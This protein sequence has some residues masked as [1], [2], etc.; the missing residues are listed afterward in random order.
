MK[1]QRPGLIAG[2]VVGVLALSACGSDNTDDTASGGD[3]STGA[4]ADCADGTLSWDG[5]SAQKTAVTEWIQK[6]QDK[7]QQA[8]INYQGQGS[9]SGRTAFY[10]GQIPVAGSDASIKDEDQ[11]KA[12]TRCTGGKAVNLPMVLTPV[13]F[14]YN[15]SG[16]TDLTLTPEILAK[17][18][19][20]K[21]I[22]WNDPEIAKANAGAS[23][24]DK[25]VTAVHRSKDSGTTENFTKFLDAQA[26]D[27]WTFGT[28]Q[29][30]TAPGG[31]GA[32]DSSGLVQS[33][34]STDGG[35]GYVDGPDA[36][37]N[38]LTPGQARRGRGRRRAERGLGR[39]G[40][41]R[42][43]GQG[44]RAGH[45]TLDQLRLEGRRHIPG[46][47]GHLRDHLHQGTAGRPDQVRQVVPHLHRQR[48][49]SGRARRPGLLPAAGR[50]GHQGPLGGRL[51]ERRADPSP[52]SRRRC[53]PPLPSD[54]AH[55]HERRRTR[56]GT[57]APEGAVPVTEQPTLGGS[58]GPSVDEPVTGEVGGSAVRRGDQVFRGLSVSAG[59][60]VLLIMAAITVFLIY[61]SIPALR[62]NTVNFLTFT[63]W[64]PDQSSAQFGIAALL[65]HTLV[66]GILAMIIAVPVA[67]GIALFITYY[68]PRRA[69]QPLGYFVDLLAAV[70]SIVYGLWGFAFLAPRLGGLTLWLDK[71]LGWIPIF[72]YQAQNR[73]NN[74]T[75]FTAG[76]V[77]AIMILPIISSI[78][79]EVFRQVPREQ[80]EAA[81][82]LGATRW[83]M[84]RTAVLPFG[85]AGVV[86]AAILGLGRALGET[87]AVTIV[88]SNVYAI[89]WHLTETGGVTFASNI[90]LK[91]GEA[92]EIGTGALIFS[93]LCLFVITLVVNFSAQLVLTRQQR[94]ANR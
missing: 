81:L 16:V 51:A 42:S 79:R 30:W 62:A 38:S 73:P 31:Q 21:I 53:A 27:V 64:L 85:R 54:G 74:L 89:S 60:T 34:K 29:A 67:I 25:T 23:L 17:I 10:G 59:A 61:R 82:A 80:V 37:K 50:A 4:S 2:L 56:E 65:F 39:Q 43:R 20:G 66:T 19:S 57:R 1:L 35:I 28:G 68:T 41:L 24:P 11:S 69:A 76:I 87:L 63:Q 32:P 86:S 18:F 45:Q 83:E 7:C 15:L 8:S 94:R 26:K 78:S 36:K 5:S 72:D 71:W 52:V 90:A 13:E 92:S 70:P 55:R 3:S 40:D 91:Y 6:Y 93:G 22:N 44:G 77:L 49:R 12:D 88:L 75:D 58:R 47:P 33:V 9:G 84:V 48:R 14:I 46:D